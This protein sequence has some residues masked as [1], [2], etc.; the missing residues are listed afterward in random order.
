MLKNF[1]FTFVLGAAVCNCL[2]TGSLRA[3]G[4]VILEVMER[5]KCSAAVTGAMLGI[6]SGFISIFCKDSAFSKVKLAVDPDCRNGLLGTI[7][8]L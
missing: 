4:I 2:F 5:F 6:M 3:M 1:H 7:S 8:V